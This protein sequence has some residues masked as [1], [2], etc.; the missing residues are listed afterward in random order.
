MLSIKNSKSCF[1]SLVAAIALFASVLALTLSYC[2]VFDIKK[3]KADENPFT[4]N[5]STFNVYHK[6]SGATFWKGEYYHLKSGAR[7]TKI[8]VTSNRD[9]DRIQVNIRLQTDDGDIACNMHAVGAAE[10]NSYPKVG[11]V[12]LNAH[13]TKE[14]II[15]SSVT[16]DRVNQIRVEAYAGST[17]EI[18][19][20]VHAAQ[21]QP[22]DIY[23]SASDHSACEQF[24]LNTPDFKKYE[25]DKYGVDVT[26]V[27]D[28]DLFMN[29][30]NQTINDAAQQASG[31][32]QKTT[33]I[34]KEG[35]CDMQAFATDADVKSNSSEYKNLMEDNKVQKVAAFSM[36]NHNTGVTTGSIY[37]QFCQTNTKTAPSSDSACWK[38]HE[39]K[40]SGGTHSA[41]ASFG[42]AGL[43]KYG[44][45]LGAFVRV[46]WDVLATSSK[47]SRIFQFGYDIQNNDTSIGN[48]KS[49]VSR[50]KHL[51]IGGTHIAASKVEEV[52]GSDILTGTPKIKETNDKNIL[53]GVMS[54]SDFLNIQPFSTGSHW[55]EIV[56]GVVAAAFI[57]LAA[58]ALILVGG[59]VLVPTGGASTIVIASG[60]VLA[61][62]AAA[63][64][65]GTAEPG[66]RALDKYTAEVLDNS[67][68]AIPSRATMAV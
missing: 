24:I 61:L 52:Q 44:V 45:P 46:K 57:F 40:V 8:Q 67:I 50:I 21:T 23:G 42:T 55:T 6:A 36:I 33:E 68:A 22:I 20:T 62:V 4:E 53:Y 28:E 25:H 56:G 66:S 51:Q 54:F 2:T 39:V 13:E 34:S 48:V 10:D 17:R 12:P 32:S 19:V 60:V 35:Y 16:V 29:E 63:T 59:L 7:D 3:A 5:V 9:D 11:K 65:A 38:Q 14:C 31:S 1:K 27:E 15:P 41:G 30:I 49:L 37:I 43:D 64:M 26:K 58:I 18:S 47:L